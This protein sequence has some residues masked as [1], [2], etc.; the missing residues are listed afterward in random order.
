[1][2]WIVLKGDNSEKVSSMQKTNLMTTNKAKK[3]G[4]KLCWQENWVA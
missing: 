2:A 4:L 3:E 1:M